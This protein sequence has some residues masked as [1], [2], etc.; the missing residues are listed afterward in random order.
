MFLVDTYIQEVKGNLY[1]NSEL[2]VSNLKRVCA[3]NFAA[4][5]ELLD[6]SAFIDPSNFEMSIM[7]FSMDKQANEVFAEGSAGFAGSEEVLPEMAYFQLEDKDRDEFFNFYE[8]NEEEIL[9]QEQSIVADWFRECW[10]KAGGLHVEFPAYF[11]FHDEYKALE[12]KS[13]Q[14]IIDDEKWT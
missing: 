12:L 7:M 2:L 14:W 8:A 9:P 11:L 4:E 1:K 3:Y 5:V 10:V 6:F 13:N